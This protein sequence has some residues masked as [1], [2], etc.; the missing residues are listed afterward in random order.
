MLIG[1][2]I[3]QGFLKGDGKAAAS[4]ITNGLSTMGNGVG[5]GVESV[6]SGTADGVLSVGQGLFSGVK[7]AGKG[8]GAAF[9]GKKAQRKPSTSK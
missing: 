3:G 5:R 6:V 1:K 9:S 7:N 8:F 2:G 4:G